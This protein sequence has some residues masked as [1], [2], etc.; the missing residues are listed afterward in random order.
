MDVRIIPE[1]DSREIGAN[2]SCAFGDK[3]QS[4]IC[5]WHADHTWRSTR[6]IVSAIRNLEATKGLNRPPVCLTGTEGWEDGCTRVEIS[7]QWAWARLGGC[8]RSKP[9]Q[10]AVTGV[11]QNR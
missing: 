11:L 2:A 9:P 3:Y 10:I 1:R 5:V 4:G 7:V 6:Q 8:S